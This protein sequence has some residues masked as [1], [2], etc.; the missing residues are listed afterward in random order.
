MALEKSMTSRLDFL[1]VIAVI[2][3][4][5]GKT[6]ECVDGVSEGAACSH[7]EFVGHLA[8]DEMNGSGEVLNDL[9]GWVDVQ[10][11]GT[12]YVIVGM[13]NGTAFARL[14]ADGT[15]VFLGRLPASDGQ[16]PVSKTGS[17]AHGHKRCHD[18]LCGEEDS[19]WRDVKVFDH[20]AYIVSEATGHGVQIFDLHELRLL[21]GSAPNGSLSLAG[22]YDGVGH[23]HNIFIN[24][25]SDDGE[26]RAYV[27]G[28]DGPGIAGGLHV[29]DL[30]DPI[31]PVKLAELDADG[32]THD[33][34]CVNY[35]GPDADFVNRELCFAS[36]EDTLTVW[37]VTDP[38]S[39]TI[40]SR[41]GYDDAAYTHQGWLSPDQRYF[42]LNDELDEQRTAERTHLRVFDVH[43][44]DAP[45]VIA[46][47]FAPSLAIDHNNYTHGRWLYQ[48]NYAAGLR[49]LDV[50]DPRH[51][52]EAAFFD[53]QLSDE[54]DFYGSWSNFLF[55]S[56]LVA[57]TDIRNGLFVV[58]PTLVENASQPDLLVSMT[59]D[60]TSVER[61][62]AV[63]G[64]L[65]VENAV[66]ADASDVLVT[67]HLPVDAMFTD[68]GE[69][70]G[71]HCDGEREVRVVL[72]RTALF[73]A[74]AEANFEFSFAASA[75]GAVLAAG[76]AY[77]E[78]ADAAPGDNLDS[79]TVTVQAAPP[80]ANSTSSGGG[81]VLWMLFA[82]FAGSASLRRR[83]VRR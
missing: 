49:I 6:A 25:N 16:S 80:P 47:Y 68:I 34:Q 32:Y 3:P 31:K 58:R 13:Q 37:D 60:A 17:H 54:P 45:R 77:A 38:V 70:S 53:P 59:L 26:G 66:A 75:G 63:T 19:A 5:A 9:W 67:L 52:V 41:T 35:S 21:D 12:E 76:M 48:S 24:E 14:A 42:Y 61:S 43:D 83:Y 33:V 22:Y 74:G 4:L 11:G 15:P 78:E 30:S 44:V 81:S 82:V 62:A 29:L 2:L 64:K 72:C 23:A 20:Y 57:F 8:P 39:A 56:G 18:D 73:T 71:W 36:N 7:I 28:H 51:P 50:H 65:T 40:I 10:N 27:V 1:L 69:P 55:P 46:D 79:V